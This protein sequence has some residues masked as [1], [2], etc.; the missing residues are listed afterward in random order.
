M[1]I[2]VHSQLGP[3]HLEATY[4][5]AACH[6]LDLRGVSYARQ[7]PVKISYKG[8]MVGSGFIDLIV[9]GKVVLELK[10][11]ESLSPTH[12]AQAGAYLAST[13]L[14]LAILANF[15]TAMMKDGIR[16]VVRSQQ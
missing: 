1:L 9:A 15:N 4:E 10:S 3:G 16:R 6:E 2:E 11:V 14:M 12:R 13:G 8:K 7:A 5:E